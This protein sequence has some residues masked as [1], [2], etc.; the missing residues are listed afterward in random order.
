MSGAPWQSGQLPVDVGSKLTV[1]NRPPQP[2]AEIVATESR[3][4]GE[5]YRPSSSVRRMNA[6]WPVSTVTLALATGWPS[7][8]RTRPAMQDFHPAK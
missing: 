5:Q 8:E 2:W 4:A 7:L 3:A 6:V 1:P